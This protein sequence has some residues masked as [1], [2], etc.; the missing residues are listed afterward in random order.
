MQFLNRTAKIFV[1]T[2][3][4]VNIFYQQPNCGFYFLNSCN[5]NVGK[6]RISDI[7]NFRQ[8][9]VVDSSKLRVATSQIRQNLRRSGALVTLCAHR[10][11]TK[12]LYFAH[13]NCLYN[14][15]NYISALPRISAYPRISAHPKL[16]KWDKGLGG[17]SKQN[18]N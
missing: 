5:S 16:R 18:G 8:S 14:R 17:Y 1:K 4:P 12:F 6:W 2:S 11:V 7:K 13:V 9:L 3:L 10:E 15:S